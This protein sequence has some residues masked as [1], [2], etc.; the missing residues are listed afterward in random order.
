M[1]QAGRRRHFTEGEIAQVREK[2][3][4]RCVIRSELVETEAVKD[5]CVE[6]LHLVRRPVHSVQHADNVQPGNVHLLLADDNPEVAQLLL[7]VHPDCGAQLLVG[8]RKRLVVAG[9]RGG[10]GDDAT[11]AATTARRASGRAAARRSGRNS[12]G[13]PGRL[14]RLG[15][16]RRSRVGIVR[17]GIPRAGR[18]FELDDS[19]RPIPAPAAATAAA[20]TP[21]PSPLV[22][23]VPLGRRWAE[24]EAEDGPVFAIVGRRRRTWSGSVAHHGREGD[25]P[26]GLAPGVVTPHQTGFDGRGRRGLGRRN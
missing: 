13:R 24:T 25:L 22:F 15:R 12:S 18:V 23:L 5:E 21:L 11:G 9:G 10:G 16:H 3:P 7:D 20:V 4:E 19:T 1:A 8:R 17:I 14:S 26:E 6:E 2:G